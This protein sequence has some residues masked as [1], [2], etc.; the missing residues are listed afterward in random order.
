[1]IADAQCRWWHG[2]PDF[3]AT[4]LVEQCFDVTAWAGRARELLRHNRRVVAAL[5]RGDHG[6]L[7]AGF[8]VGAATLQHVRNDPLLPDELLPSR[9]PGNELRDAYR[10]YERAF[11]DTVADWFRTSSSRS[12]S[13]RGGQQ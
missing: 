2:A 3:D 8:I 9:W 11:S 4:A 6:S 1:V 10:S 7:R 5:E 13:R 12:T